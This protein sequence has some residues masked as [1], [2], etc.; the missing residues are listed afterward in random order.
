MVYPTSTRLCQEPTLEEPVQ[1][2][3]V[4]GTLRRGQGNNRILIRDGAKFIEEVWLYGHAMRG[5]LSVQ[6]AG[7]EYRVRGDIWEVPTKCLLGPIDS[8]EAHP[9]GWIRTWIP[10]QHGGTW[11]YLDTHPDSHEHQQVNGDIN[12]NWHPFDWSAYWYHLW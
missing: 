1:R 9:Y 3:F 2:L 11:I 12:R 8:L 7:P 5:M 4:Y 6:V 10:D